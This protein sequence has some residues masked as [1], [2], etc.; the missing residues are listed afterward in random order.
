LIGAEGFVL[1]NSELCQNS[2]LVTY[3]YEKK[4]KKETKARTSLWEKNFRGYHF[5]LQT[6]IH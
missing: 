3:K 1:N 5:T 2:N 4:K 6:Y